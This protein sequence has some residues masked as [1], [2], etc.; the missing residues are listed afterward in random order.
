MILINIVLSI[1]VHSLFFKIIIKM[2]NFVH[3]KNMIIVTSH[4]VKLLLIFITSIMSHS[5]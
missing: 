3:I 4:T 5:S 2:R 1:A